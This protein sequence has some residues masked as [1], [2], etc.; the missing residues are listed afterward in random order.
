M[1]ISNFENF[2]LDAILGQHL[3]LFI[4]VK[5]QIIGW[6]LTKVPKLC[7][8]STLKFKFFVN[9]GVIFEINDK[10]HYDNL[11][12]FVVRPCGSI[13]MV[14]IGHKMNFSRTAGLSFLTVQWDERLSFKIVKLI[15]TNSELIC[16]SEK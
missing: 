5:F 7:K 16:G 2:E 3:N 13:V 14:N 9:F 1:A 10:N 4:S 6:V 15:K 8:D 11:E 12:I